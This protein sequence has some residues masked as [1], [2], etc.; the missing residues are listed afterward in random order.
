MVEVALAFPFGA[1]FVRTFVVKVVQV[2]AVPD[3]R[4][5]LVVVTSS[6]E[7]IAAEAA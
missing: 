4:T 6:S 1:A 3:S 2:A 7:T 5:F